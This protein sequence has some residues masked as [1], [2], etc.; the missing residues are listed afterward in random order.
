MTHTNNAHNDSREPFH[1]NR[2]D[3]D[4][5]RTSLGDSIR[6]VLTK[7]WDLISLGCHEQAIAHR[8]AVYLESRFPTY[9]TDCEYN[10]RKHFVKD[11][12]AESSKA[13][14]NMR[15]D[16][17]V[18][19]RN[20][21]HNV[22]AVEMKANAN[23]K[24]S[25]D[26]EKL[27]ALYSDAAYLYKATAFVRIFNA[28]KEI[29]HGT[30]RAEVRWYDVTDKALNE[31]EDERVTIDVSSSKNEVVEIYKARRRGRKGEPG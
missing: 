20:S 25:R 22:L 26:P 16:I 31:R 21:V 13:K 27:K 5:I 15:P 2:P 7:D 6:E 28:L 8:I 10:R 4:M 14:K 12:P 19:R 29:Q 9:H 11:Y 30:L 23:N 18:H 3:Y 24:T 1:L 17:I